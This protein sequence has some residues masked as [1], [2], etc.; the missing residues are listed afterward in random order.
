M[1]H[2]H[3]YYSSGE[4]RNGRVSD[5]LTAVEKGG[6][7]VKAGLTGVAALALVLAVL[8]PAAAPAAAAQPRYDFKLEELTTGD[9]LSMALLVEDKPLV[10]HVW[11]PD[12]PHCQRH[13][14]YLVAFYKKLDLDTV[15]FVTCSMS[16]SRKDAEEYIDSKRLAFPVMYCEGGKIS[17]SFSSNGWPT[18]FVFAPGGKYVGMCDTQSSSYVSEMLD[19]VDK[20]LN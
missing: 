6:R 20:A 10:V 11:A 16:D 19:L 7:R 2:Q 4:L 1:T 9:T 14:P 18:T 13:M 8:Q 3:G 5:M 12:C 15:N 17:D